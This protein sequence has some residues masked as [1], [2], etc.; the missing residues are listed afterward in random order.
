MKSERATPFSTITD[1]RSRITDSPSLSTTLIILWVLAMIGLPIMK[2]IWGPGTIPLGLTL[3]VLLQATAVFLILR[4]RWGWQK[5]AGTVV[6]IATL[7]LFVEWLGSTTGFPFGSYEYTD[8]M[9]PQIA[10]VP[11]LIPFA[12]F[13]MLPCA[14]AIAHRIQ[15]QLSSR[16]ATNRWLYPLLAG[17]AL[18]AW[19]LF[20]DPQMVAWGLWVWDSPG[21][22]FGIP[23]SN[24]LGWLG[25]AVLLTALIRPKDLPIKPLLIIYTITWFLETFGLLFFW[26]LAGPALVGGVVMGVFVWLSWCSL[27]GNR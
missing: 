21:G 14:W 25:T 20:L 4:D 8:L 19:D 2:W 17:L 15:A 7:T 23:W 3:G 12:W 13:M 16:W 1:Y 9:Q 26:R 10:H 18:T 6:L 22:Y 5:T 27:L 11:I 24:Y